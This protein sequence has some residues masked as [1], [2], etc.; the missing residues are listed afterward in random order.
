MEDFMLQVTCDTDSFEE[1]YINNLIDEL[2]V[3]VERKTWM[4]KGNEY[5]VFDYRPFITGEFTTHYD[6]ISNNQSKLDF[7]NFLIQDRQLKVDTLNNILEVV[8]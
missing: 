7:M 2:G 5:A 8:E 6:I 4:M 3:T 1:D